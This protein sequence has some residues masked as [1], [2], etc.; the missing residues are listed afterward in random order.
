MYPTAWQ[1]AQP[2]SL[3]RITLRPLALNR[4]PVPLL[5]VCQVPRRFPHRVL[6]IE[7]RAF[8]MEKRKQVRTT[9]NRRQVQDRLILAPP[10]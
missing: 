2:S 5:M 7:S 6:R 8:R 3:L 4:L 10:V 1:P 9:L